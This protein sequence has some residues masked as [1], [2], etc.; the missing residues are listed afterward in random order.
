MSQIVLSFSN[1]TFCAVH[2][3]FILNLKE[4]KL[5]KVQIKM[6]DYMTI[7][8]EKSRSLSQMLD[9]RRCSLSLPHLILAITAAVHC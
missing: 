2:N 6:K 9:R 5:L 8:G 4:S 1:V 7:N 3:H